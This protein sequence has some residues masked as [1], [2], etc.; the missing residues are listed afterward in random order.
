MV[1]ANKANA[2][3]AVILGSDELA[4]NVATLKDL[5]SGEQKTV[6][7]SNLIEELK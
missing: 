2:V 7:L 4:Q 1:K 3:K 5:D 6:S